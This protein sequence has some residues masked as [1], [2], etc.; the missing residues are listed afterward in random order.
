MRLKINKHW[1][2]DHGVTIAGFSI[3]IADALKS[4]DW[5][6]FDISKEWP[7]ILL[8]CVIAGGGWFLKWKLQDA[9]PKE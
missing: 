7:R 6:N 2:A 5:A 3:A 1:I 4:I 8:D 9:K